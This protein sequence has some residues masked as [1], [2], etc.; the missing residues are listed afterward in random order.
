MVD[1]LA[2]TGMDPFVPLM[3]AALLVLAG[4]GAAIVAWRRGHAGAALMIGLVLIVA[5]L[6]FGSPQSASAADCSSSSQGGEAPAA[7]PAPAESTGAEPACTPAV[8]VADVE[9]DGGNWEYEGGIWTLP[10]P[11]E[12]EAYREYMTAMAAVFEI[13][14]SAAPV[15]VVLVAHNGESA[16]LTR[17]TLTAEDF[18]GTG[19]GGGFDDAL[20]ERVSANGYPDDMVMGYT[21]GY[22]D[23]CGGTLD[24]TIAVRGLVPLF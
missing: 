11:S 14:R 24:T 23:G 17:I 1:C 12:G 18:G 8:A 19:N 22:S 5:P 20:F 4:V 6:S 21:F 2:S 15:G 13:D 10:V 7:A 16:E 3:I 9:I